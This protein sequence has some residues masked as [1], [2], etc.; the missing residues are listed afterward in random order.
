M[1]AWLA[2]VDFLRHY[3]VAAM[4]LVFSLIVVKAYWP[5]RRDEQQLPAL[6]PFREER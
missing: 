5:G 3:V 2:W 6:I 1:S 4:V